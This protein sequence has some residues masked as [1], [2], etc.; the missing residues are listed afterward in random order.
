MNKTLK[1]KSKIWVTQSHPRGLDSAADFEALGLDVVS[2]PLLSI[3]FSS[4]PIPSPER[5]THL[6]F[7]ARNGVRT[8]VEKH[9]ERDFAVTCVGDATAALAVENGFTQVTSAKGDAQDVIA[10]IRETVPQSIPL[11]HC[12]GRYVRGQIVETLKS[13]G[14][15]AERIEY[16]ASTP[17]SSSDL[18]VSDFDYVALYSPLAARTFRDLLKDKDVSGLK[19]LSI[20]TATDDILDGLNV[21]D[22]HIAG[23]PNQEAMMARLK[24]D[25][26]SQ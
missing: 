17:I 14:Y 20:S 11:R 5:S 21:K 2:S 22:R 7:T 12:A 3:A 1:K 24:L 16:Y 15:N 18:D 13:L 19:T 9:T 6:I 25:L 10:L 26:E 4:D 23:R 8:F